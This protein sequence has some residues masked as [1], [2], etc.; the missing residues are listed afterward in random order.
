MKNAIVTVTGGT[1]YIASWI[2]NDL[3]QQGHD[4]RITVRDK[5]KK[6]KYQHLLDIAEK[7]PGTLSVYE[8]DLL[9]NGSFFESVDGAAYVMHTASPFFLDDKG[10]TR[11]K[12]IDPAVTGT[13]NLLDSVNRTS[14][15]KRVVLTSSIAAIYGD[16]ID[17]INRNLD[18][19]DETLWNESSSLIHNAYSFSKTLAEKAAW[20][21]VEKQNAWDLVTILPGFV[22]GPSLTKRID[23][24]S[25]N[26][27]LRILRGELKSGA[28]DLE[29]IFSD[30]RDISKAHLLAAFEP[31]ARGRYIISNESGNLLTL[32]K[33]IEK[34]FPGNY[35]VPRK[36]I[37]K[38]LV[39]ILAPSV[40]FTRKYVTNN[41]GFPLKAN[42]SRSIEDLGI[43]YNSLEKTVVDHVEQLER[44]H[45]L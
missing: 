23:S 32:G 33:I 41:I 2:V 39:W 31:K 43:Q 14:S 36:Q 25:I 6:E 5:E 38:W 4:V 24:T 26:T 17:M 28:P 1:G 30:V 18:A 16:N 40:G 45:L 21:M 37:P 8:A 29:F 35:R 42:N 12:L 9:T 34:A 10:D 20:E 22:L 19:L 15:V 7:S 3:L 11:I 44:D 27:L 13:R